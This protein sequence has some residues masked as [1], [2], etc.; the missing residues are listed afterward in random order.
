M[1][2]RCGLEIDGNG[3][4]GIV[5]LATVFLMALDES[6]SVGRCGCSRKRVEPDPQKF[7]FAGTCIRNT[8]ANKYILGPLKP[9]SPPTRVRS[10]AWRT[11]RGS[12]S[13]FRVRGPSSNGFRVWRF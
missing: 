8:F 1:F 4:L 5:V 3:D 2:C 6:D 10:L 11:H 12:S 7:C 13:I 9:P